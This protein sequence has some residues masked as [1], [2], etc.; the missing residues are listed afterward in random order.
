MS[1]LSSCSAFP[2]SQSQL[3]QSG[4]AII[5]NEI[6][7]KPFTFI[8]AATANTPNAIAKAN[9]NAAAAIKKIPAKINRIPSSINPTFTV[10]PTPN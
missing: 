10:T 9:L 8:A 4:Y 3:V 2:Q 5:G 1:K 6:L 7:G